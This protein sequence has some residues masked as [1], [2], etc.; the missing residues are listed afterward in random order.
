M[1]CIILFYFYVSVLFR[2]ARSTK[3]ID[4]SD[5]SSTLAKK[6][7]KRSSLTPSTDLLASEER[8]RVVQGETIDAFEQLQGVALEHLSSVAFSFYCSYF[9]ID[10]Q[11]VAIKFE[12]K[13]ILACELAHFQIKNKDSVDLLTNGEKENPI[14]VVCEYLE[15]S[16]TDSYLNLLSFDCFIEFIC[17]CANKLVT[18]MLYLIKKCNDR[19]HMGCGGKDNKYAIQLLQDMDNI[20]N[21]LKLIVKSIPKIPE[22]SQYFGMEKNDLI[23]DVIMSKLKLFEYARLLLDH[24]PDPKLFIQMMQNI[25]T[26]ASALDKDDKSPH[27]PVYLAYYVKALVELRHNKQLHANLLLEV[28]KQGAISGGTGIGGVTGGVPSAPRKSVTSSIL[29]GLVTPNSGESV[30]RPSM[31]SNIFSG[32]NHSTEGHADNHAHPSALANSIMKEAADKDFLDE[33]D[34]D[35]ED[36]EDDEEE[37]EANLNCD[38][39]IIM[40]DKLIS[41][42]VIIATAKDAKNSPTM[43]VSLILH[44]NNS[45][46]EFSPLRRV[47]DSSSVYYMNKTE[48]FTID[49][50]PLVAQILL[51]GVGFKQLFSNQILQCA[52]Q[53]TAKSFTAGVAGAAV[54]SVGNAMLSAAKGTANVAKETASAAKG[55]ITA[56]GGAVGVTSAATT[57]AFGYIAHAFTPSHAHANETSN[58][59]LN[60]KFSDENISNNS[61]NDEAVHQSLDTITE[62]LMDEISVSSLSRDP[63]PVTMPPV[64]PV[65]RSTTAVT[66]KQPTPEILQSKAEISVFG[67]RLFNLFPVN[68]THIDAF[69]KRAVDS[70][71]EVS[72]HCDKFKAKD[73]LGTVDLN[74]TVKKTEIIHN[75]T[76]PVFQHDSMHFVLPTAF[77]MPSASTKTNIVFKILQV[78]KVFNS[79]V[80]TVTICVNDL[81]QGNCSLVDGYYDIVWEDAV[82]TS[83]EKAMMEGNVKNESLKGRL[84]VSLQLSA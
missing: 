54:K 44:D 5:T 33:G 22:D 18:V 43:H 64:A 60:R 26:D 68:K 19:Y 1:S 58:P 7:P 76:S 4:I 31:F 71:V 81:F 20:E 75:S 70:F 8:A 72:L 16:L 21:C 67:V 28:K 24:K 63:S 12:D 9:V 38:S 15:E 47:F 49:T 25:L 6:S 36:E 29:G 45:L 73:F 59:I 51:S 61:N 56:I 35:D 57:A 48:S 65:T 34:D 30:R 2:R 50:I 52:K 53:V 80:G 69:N 14:T 42:H 37:D 66:D 62:G 78:G 84:H 55:T 10:D 3:L 17:I 39:L 41:D 32:G 82:K 11:N 83:A 23:R 77:A 46:H 27:E 79:H 74:K 40:V 13:W